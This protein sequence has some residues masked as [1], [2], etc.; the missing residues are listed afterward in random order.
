MRI[1]QSQ[2]KKTGSSRSSFTTTAPRPSSL[3]PSHL[4]C[5]MWGKYQQASRPVTNLS[6]KNI[7]WMAGLRG[8]H[9]LV[10]AG[11]RWGLILFGTNHPSHFPCPGPASAVTF[12]MCNVD[13]E[14]WQG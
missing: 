11:D 6:V 9:W 10:G 2:M 13:D 3:P 1:V 4:W 7:L 8:R 5:V 12:R 14:H